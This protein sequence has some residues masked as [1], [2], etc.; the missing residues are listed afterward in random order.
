MKNRIYKKI[1]FASSYLIIFGIAT[2]VFIGC[3]SNPKDN[4]RTTQANNMIFY[5]DKNITVY[6]D[7]FNTG[8]Y[9]Y[10]KIPQDID[11]EL[12]ITSIS[13]LNEI[14]DRKL[15]IEFDR[16]IG[17]KRESV[18][19][20]YSLS[21]DFKN[22]DI[23]SFFSNPKTLLTE[24]TISNQTA[25]VY[26]PHSQSLS[27]DNF[28]GHL[29]YDEVKDSWTNSLFQSSLEYN[30]TS[31]CGSDTDRLVDGGV[32]HEDAYVQ[33][34]DEC[35]RECVIEGIHFHS[36]YRISMYK[37]IYQGDK[38]IY[39]RWIFVNENTKDIH[40][41][42]IHRT[43]LPRPLIFANVGD[44]FG[45][46]E[47]A[48]AQITTNN[49]V[50]YNKTKIGQTDIQL[51]WISDAS[52]HGKTCH[53][54]NASAQERFMRDEIRELYPHHAYDYI[55]VACSGATLRNI[56]EVKQSGKQSSS[57]IALVSQWMKDNNYN[58][59]DFMLFSGGGND[60][61]FSELIQRY[62]GIK[63][64]H[65]RF[66]TP[67]AG[68]YSDTEIFLSYF[69][70]NMPYGDAEFSF[71]SLTF[72][73]P[74]MVFND[75]Y[76]THIENSKQNFEK[77]LKVLRNNFE[78]TAK[79]I[80]KTINLN[81]ILVF[82]YPNILSDCRTG[83]HEDIKIKKFYKDYRV[84]QEYFSFITGIPRMILDIS[85]RES[86][87]IQNNIA[88]FARDEKGL[89]YEIKE[90]VQNID[91]S[92]MNQKWTY[93]YNL[94]SSENGKKGICQ[95]LYNNKTHSYRRFNI[96]YD[97]ICLTDHRMTDIDMANAYHPNIYGHND[98]YLPNIR[99]SL[100]NDD[101]TALKNNYLRKTY[102]NENLSN[103]PDLIVDSSSSIVDIKRVYGS[104]D[105]LKL[106]TTISNLGKMDAINIFVNYSLID[107]H[108]KHHTLKSKVSLRTVLSP[109]RQKGST[110]DFKHEYP[111][112]IKD[113]RIINFS[114][115]SDRRYFRRVKAT[116]EDI[117]LAWH[118]P[119]EFSLYTY[120]GTDN[121]EKN[122]MNNDFINKTQ[123]IKIVPGQELREETIGAVLSN[124][125][126]EC[127]TDYVYDDYNREN[128]K[129][130]K[131][132]DITTKIR[133]SPVLYEY[134]EKTSCIRGFFHLANNETRDEEN[135]RMLE[136][137][138]EKDLRDTFPKF[139]Q[140]FSKDT[141][142]QICIIVDNGEMNGLTQ[143]CVDDASKLDLDY[144]N[145][146]QD[147]RVVEALI[148]NSKDTLKQ[149]TQAIRI[150]TRKRNAGIVSVSN[151]ENIV[152]QSYVYNG[153]LNRE[154]IDFP[155]QE[156]PHIIEPTIDIQSSIRLNQSRLGLV[157]NNIIDEAK[158]LSGIPK[159]KLINSSIEFKIS[160]VENAKAY[161]I[162]I[163]TQKGNYD[164]LNKEIA[165]DEPLTIT[166]NNIPQNGKNIYVTVKTKRADNKWYS[167]EYI[168][169]TSK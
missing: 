30:C 10:I 48:G 27:N 163:G 78:E 51:G 1:T 124:L 44:S 76:T 40:Y 140:T 108:N 94:D 12:G 105:S 90:L 159:E 54:A 114:K 35:V 137:I 80:N 123:T 28:Y 31:N 36:A 156:Q 53:R 26:L 100:L 42:D 37:S 4:N 20:E 104:N 67:I 136:D 86:S 60:V 131:E 7:Y 148:Y 98:I 55:N 121:A 99:K 46:G 9:Q 14:G 15:S 110:K 59:I 112:N 134:S 79:V 5:Q 24:A 17:K 145:L 147:G 91:N 19:L 18:Y 49:K 118:F 85:K 71:S 169:G 127:G 103:L 64:T 129:L 65:T 142:S 149:H 111:I 160:K 96:L 107:K 73:I 81:E 52:Y 115:F 41:G 63:F 158:I 139:E 144:L 102:E 166:V 43:T 92:N 21:F 154:L 146:P 16:D 72:L 38:P 88:G 120:V 152:A 89:N 101:K 106:N 82:E 13:G 97:A 84:L 74:A 130:I 47:G 95:P 50:T 151:S 133:N 141:D 11:K 33:D 126:H 69:N 128:N 29:E 70:S 77:H 109:L 2:G 135:E 168:Y 161:Q 32:N 119:Q 3:E 83:Y 39:Y 122:K 68:V 116:D 58:K 164:I 93:A 75:V 25:S 150:K 61:R 155:I 56:S 153:E 45:S 8:K 62:L 132:S 165:K 117:V 34:L 87:D 66:L 138:A 157:Q 22:L 162:I 167:E 143:E 113:N 57:Q 6:S 125:N 23:G